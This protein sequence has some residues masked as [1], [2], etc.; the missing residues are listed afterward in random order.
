[1]KPTTAPVVAGQAGQI[2]HASEQTLYLAQ[3]RK[4]VG[5]ALEILVHHHDALEELIDR[6][7]EIDQRTQGL[8]VAA[9]APPARTRAPDPCERLPTTR[10]SSASA[11]CDSPNNAAFTDTP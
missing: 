10:Y 11:P 5:A 3:Q 8:G 9:P 6:R 4:P 1:V 7:R 2:D